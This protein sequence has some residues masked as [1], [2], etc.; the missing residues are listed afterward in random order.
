MSPACRLK[1]RPVP[2]PPINVARNSHAFTSNVESTSLELQRFRVVSK[3][4]RGKLRAKFVWRLSGL[5][6]RVPWLAQCLE[7]RPCSPDPPPSAPGCISGCRWGFAPLEASLRRVAG[8]SRLYW[9]NSPRLVA[10][11]TW[12]EPDRGPLMVRF[13]P[14]AGGEAAV[15]G[16]AAHA[17]AIG[18]TCEVSDPRACHRTH[19]R[20]VGP[21]RIPSD[22]RAKCR[23]HVRGEERRQLAL[24]AVSR[25]I[26]LSE[27]STAS[28]NVAILTTW[29]R[30]TTQCRWNCMRHSWKARPA[31]VILR[32]SR[33][34]SSR[35]R[36][37][38][39]GL[40]RWIPPR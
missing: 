29:M 18:P 39:S 25:A 8:V 28:T 27:L 11:S 3:S 16:G 23:A 24:G 37:R 30:G 17:H 13:P 6:P 38:A 26:R 34:R 35:S 4:D 22:P 14:F 15:R 12:G 1:A 36:W 9:C 21:T 5:R 40:A 33:C 32:R 20:S 10:P 2:A 19:V 7:A 31:G